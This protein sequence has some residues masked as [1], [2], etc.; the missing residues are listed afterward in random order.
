LK[1]KVLTFVLHAG[2]L[3]IERPL[4]EVAVDG[5]A[6]VLKSSGKLVK[7]FKWVATLEV[8]KAIGFKLKGLVRDLEEYRR[9]LVHDARMNELVAVATAFADQPDAQRTEAMIAILD[10]TADV[11]DATL[12]I[13]RAVREALVK[14]LVIRC[15]SRA[16]VVAAPDDMKLFGLLGKVLFKSRD[17]K[18]EADDVLEVV[19]LGRQV[20][21]MLCRAVVMAA[22]AKSHDIADMF[23]VFVNF[24]KSVAIFNQH[25]FATAVPD[26]HPD[27]SIL[28]AWM[29]SVAE[30]VKEQ[31]QLSI[32]VLKNAVGHTLS[33]DLA[34]AFGY[35]Q[36]ST[37]QCRT[38]V[39]NPFRLHA[40]VPQFGCRFGAVV[41][42]VSFRPVQTW[43]SDLALRR[44]FD[45]ICPKGSSRSTVSRLILVYFIRLR[46]DLG[47][48]QDLLALMHSLNE[49]NGGGKDV[50]TDWKTGLDASTPLKTLKE[51]GE[52]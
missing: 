1:E 26:D 29:T 3:V 22:D 27:R 15:T 24:T 46:A 16:S 39:G 17:G 35:S 2:P 18:S 11:T 31:Q 37:C 33:T 30:W 10:K 32:A 19:S 47:A 43:S 42:S 25:R 6:V 45:A 51:V 49:V 23:D 48:V 8:P 38:S 41:E 7:L 12:P 21:D 13:L 14:E 44:L 28:T 40:G 36:L 9:L 5:K 52:A 50:K 34:S 20:L 4:S